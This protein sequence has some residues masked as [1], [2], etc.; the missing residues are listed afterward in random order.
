MP[1]LAHL[2]IYWTSKGTLYEHPAW[3]ATL[4]SALALALA[5]PIY[6]WGMA[7][8]WETGK[9]RRLSLHGRFTLHTLLSLEWVYTLFWRA[10]RPLSRL[11]DFTNRVL[12]GPAGILWALLILILLISL[13]TP[14]RLG[15]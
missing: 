7:L 15:G 11:A 10:Y 6:F 5:F 1:P 9:R 3:V 13:V 14:A 12:E 8:F 2:L 4:L